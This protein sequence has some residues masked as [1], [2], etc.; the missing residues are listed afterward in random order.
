MR[1]LFTIQL[2]TACC[3]A[4][5]LGAVFLS[6]LAGPSRL[7]ADDK[8]KAE[9]DVLTAD[10]LEKFLKSALL[11][12]E[13]QSKGTYQMTLKKKVKEE[14]WTMYFVVSLSTDGSRV[15]LSSRWST[16]PGSSTIPPDITYKIL[17]ANNAFA[18]AS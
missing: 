15:L 10:N 2:L 13:M 17:V 3:A 1:K 14:T 7:A 4:A 8:A 12:P 11:K 18:P 9:P 16:V 5:L 6:G